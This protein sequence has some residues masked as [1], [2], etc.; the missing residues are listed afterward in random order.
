MN[1]ARDFLDA[2]EAFAMT[3]GKEEGMALFDCEKLV[4]GQCGECPGCR[5]CV[6]A[7]ELRKQL[8]NEASHS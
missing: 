8:T 4:W 7:T 1:A 2:V 3:Y 5:V 6:T